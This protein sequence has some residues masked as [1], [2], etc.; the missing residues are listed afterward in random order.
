MLQQAGKWEQADVQFHRVIYAFPGVPESTVFVLVGERSA[1]PMARGPERLPY[2]SESAD[3]RAA[4]HLSL[5]ENRS[6][7]DVTL[8]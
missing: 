4:L 2:P 8:E 6:A 3:I 1:L 7:T 5:V